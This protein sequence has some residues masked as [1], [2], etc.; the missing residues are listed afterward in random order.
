MTLARINFKYWCSFAF[1]SLDYA[2]F[3]ETLSDK[4]KL[5]IKVILLKT[6]YNYLANAK[7]IKISRG[8]A[9]VKE[10]IIVFKALYNHLISKFMVFLFF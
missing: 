9:I 5:R 10:S 8:I 2:N 4:Y 3:L 1:N 7:I 6:T